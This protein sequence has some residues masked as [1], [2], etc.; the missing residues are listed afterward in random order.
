MNTKTTNNMTNQVMTASSVEAN[1]HQGRELL[2][3]LPFYRFTFKR[4]FYRFTFKMLLVLLPLSCTTYHAYQR[5]DLPEQ[6]VVRPQLAAST[7]AQ[8]TDSLPTWRQLFTDSH[9][10]QLI[11]EAID[12]NADLR[13][14][15]LKVDEALASLRQTR[16]GLLPTLSLQ[17]TGST[18]S[19]DGQAAR[20]TYA[21]G[22]QASW[23][24]DIMGRLSAAKRSA[25]ATVEEQQAEA[26]AIQTAVV[27][28]VAESYYRLLMYDAQI[29]VANT[30]VQSWRHYTATLQ[31]LCRAGMAT[32]ADVEQAEASRL[33]AQSTAA[34]LRQDALTT[35][36]ALCALLGRL[37][38]TIHRGTLY[39]Q[40]APLPCTRG[41]TLGRLAARPDIRAAESQLEAAHYS[42]GEARA[43][44]YPQLTLTGGAQWTNSGGTA[45]THPGALLLQAAASLAQPLYSGGR[46]RAR[47]A[48]AQARQ[49]QAAIQWQQRLT[50]AAAE[51]NDALA[52]WHTAQ[53][54]MNSANEKVDKLERALIT[55]TSMMEHGQANGLQVIVARQS[56]LSAQLNQLQ[57]RY[58]QLQSVVTLYRAL[59]GGTQ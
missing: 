53:Q 58:S 22:P 29:A 45:I 49:Q 59:G 23:E 43:A 10:Q 14:A 3:V 2:T 31:A 11:A 13:I 34:T 18:S 51:V 54:T 48:A 12:S 57:C 52:A 44:L 56:L 21:I 33:E 9:L 35:E 15:H 7:G 39:Q 20:H 30:T 26:Q 5:G 47:L 41:I 16:A 19:Y 50:E 36:H 55:M 4:P 25:R 27:A 32:T 42:V 6:S 38:G 24:A 37:P 17:A 1:S 40:Q 46:N 28:T 8:A